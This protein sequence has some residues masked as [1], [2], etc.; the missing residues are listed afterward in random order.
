MFL[1]QFF[2]LV[3]HRPLSFLPNTTLVF[4]VL[5]FSSPRLFLLVTHCALLPRSLPP[6]SS[7]NNQL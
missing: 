5:A 1:L 2:T 7:V 6:T 4:I 3:N